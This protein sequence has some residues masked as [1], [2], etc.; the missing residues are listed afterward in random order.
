LHDHGDETLEAAD[1]EQ[2]GEFSSVANRPPLRIGSDV[3]SRM[4]PAHTPS[5][6]PLYRKIALRLIPFLMLLYMVAFL[7]RV[8]VS[9]AALT[10]NRDLG[11]SDSFYGVAAGIFFLGYCVFEIPAN[12]M[13][14]RIGAR[15][16]I[17]SLVFTW[18]LVTVSTAFVHGRTD[19]LVMRCLLGVVEAGFFP[20]VIYY[21]TLWVPR[22]MRARLMALFLLAIPVCSFIGSPISAHILLLDR[23]ANLRGWQW[24]FLMEG[25][26]AVVLGVLAWFILADSPRV[27]P[28]LSAEE[29][30]A[31]LRELQAGEENEQPGVGVSADPHPDIERQPA[32][33]EAAS[34]PLA[35]RVALDALVYFAANSATY[36][37]SF[38]LPK[39]LVADGVSATAS[40][41][42][43]ALPYGVGSVAMLLLSRLTG[44]WWLGGLYLAAAVGFATA[45][46]AHNFTL[47]IAGF[48]LAAAGIFGAFPLFWSASTGHMSA[49]V[50]GPAIATVNS[51]GVLG[52]FVAPSAMGW[53]LA[54]THSHAAGLCSLAACLVIGSLLASVRRQNSAPAPNSTR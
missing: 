21:L 28:W 10:M 6:S 38:W 34:R 1:C 52:G 19:Y 3:T 23:V 45:G 49:R 13:L 18:G 5:T 27:V 24:L 12:L 46:L 2:R 20:G 31:L 32:A 4:A 39:I 16:W 35:A 51:I 11:I 30:E 53:L 43:A 7:D 25:A 47:S 48:C 15:R 22:P 54:S 42:W 26:P 36:G 44:R 8:N 33:S 29:K 14:A 9:F 37:L 40:G 41:W 50:A 17:A